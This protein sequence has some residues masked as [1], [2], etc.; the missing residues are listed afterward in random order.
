MLSLA[1]IRQ[2]KPADLDG[3][4]AELG[5]HRDTL[6]A[7]DDDLA[8]AQHPAGWMSELRPPQDGTPQ[9]VADWWAALSE[10]ERAIL[11]ASR[12]EL[13]GNLDGIPAQVRD[14]ANRARLTEGSASRS[15]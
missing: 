10:S 14:A 2:W 1:D 8:R 5:T 6:V 11:A 9:Q 7:L 4:F 15:G 13:L 3:A 12:P